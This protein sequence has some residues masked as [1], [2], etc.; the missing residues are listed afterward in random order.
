MQE[1]TSEQMV[2]RIHVLTMDSNVSRKLLADR[3][4]LEAIGDILI[5]HQFSSQSSVS[6]NEETGKFEIKE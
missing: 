2:S 1:L 3:K 4:G 5:K 6:F